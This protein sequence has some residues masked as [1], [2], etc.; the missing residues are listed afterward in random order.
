MKKIELE[1]FS[2]NC[3]VIGQDGEV[4]SQKM[5]EERK[6]RQ[7]LIQIEREGRKQ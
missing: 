7:K 5:A 6:H 1:A 2:I 3:R 4:L